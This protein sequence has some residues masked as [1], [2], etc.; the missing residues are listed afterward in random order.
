VQYAVSVVPASKVYIGVAGYGR[1]WVTAVSGVCPVDVASVISTGA[2]AAT[3]V[4]R[5]ATNLAASYGVVPTYTSKYAEST[6]TYQKVYNGLTSKGVATQC[7]ATRTAWFQDSQGYAVRANLVGKYRLGGITA[8]TLGME[9]PSA[10]PAVRTVAKSIAPDVVVATLAANSA[11]ATLGDAVTLT[12]KFALPDSRPITGLAAR[13]E[14]KNSLGDWRT[15]FNGVTGV[16]GRIS[17]PIILGEATSVRVVSDG[18]W[19]RLQGLSLPL[20]ISIKRII[21]WT[22]LLLLRRGGRSRFQVPSNRKFQE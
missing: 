22:F 6:F 3:F 21:L 4:M 10:M 17:T 20:G 9:D 15:V 14:I 12:G 8:W 7:T 13:V 18:S 1:D 19:E 11:T 5:D 2:K 16:D